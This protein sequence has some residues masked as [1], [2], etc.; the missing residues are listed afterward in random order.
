MESKY[1]IRVMTLLREI[2][3]GKIEREVSLS[4]LVENVC[5]TNELNL[6]LNAYNVNLNKLRVD[7]YVKGQV[8]I[9]VHGEQHVKPVRFSNEEEDLEEALKRRKI[10]D[11]I[12]QESLNQAGIPFICVWY[13]EIDNLTKADLEN[14]INIAIQSAKRIVNPNL[15]VKEIKPKISEEVKKQRLQKAREIRKKIYQA[16]KEKQRIR[17]AYGKI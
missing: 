17:K 15:R 13:D 7:I 6:L 14:R 5:L 9:E 16:R 11:H 12:K 2:Y 10:L 4:K 8:A 1:L 3:K